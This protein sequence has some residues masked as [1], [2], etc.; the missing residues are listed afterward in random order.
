M[1]QSQDIENAVD[2]GTRMVACRDL[3]MFKEDILEDLTRFLGAETSAFLTFFKRDKVAVGFNCAYGISEKMHQEYVDGFFKDDPA[4]DI[5][6]GGRPFAQDA[7]ASDVILLEQH[8]DYYNFTGGFFYNTF[9]RPLHIHHL[10]LIK[11]MMRPEEDSAILIGMHR[12]KTKE[13]FS[14]EHLQKAE[15][16]IPT[17]AGAM[18]SLIAHD[19]LEERQVIIDRLAHGMEKTGLLILN[20]TMDVLYVSS[21]F[22]THIGQNSLPVT[23]LP[24]NIIHICQ[25]IKH[26]L[27]RTG[28][29]VSYVRK[30]CH[31]ADHKISF[32]ITVCKTESP[33]NGL[34]FI[35]YSNEATAPS[36]SEGLMEYYHLTRREK[37]IACQ[38]TF[39]LTNIQIAEKLGI[40]MRTVENHLRAIYSKTKVKNR[41]S[42]TY[43]LSQANY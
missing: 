5:V 40:S 1:L 30:E 3:S 34:R 23:S 6:F 27:T 12:P 21:S 39:G 41:T 20:D 29:D 7:I 14:P 28:G 36:P 32:N 19:L 2:I 9:L 35:I 38:V 13:S 10:M 43:M 4:V 42:L 8:M 25:R 22:Q 24:E 11:I 16:I 31:S 33:T 18:Y 17:I 15:M 37:D 26:K